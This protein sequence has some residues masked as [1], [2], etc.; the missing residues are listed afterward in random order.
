MTQNQ[1]HSERCTGSGSPG[2]L[3]SK[4]ITQLVVTDGNRYVGFIHLHDLIRE[5]II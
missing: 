5:G 2:I 1:D 3:R 4:D